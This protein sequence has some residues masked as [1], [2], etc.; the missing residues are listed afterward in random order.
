[1]KHMKS[2]E[3]PAALCMADDYVYH[4]AE[5]ESHLKR[6]SITSKKDKGNESVK[7]RM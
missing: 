2:Y 7:Y 6:Y 5:A 1:M 4:P 3:T